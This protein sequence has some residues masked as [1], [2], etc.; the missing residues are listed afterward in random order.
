MNGVS[1]AEKAAILAH[2]TEIAALVERPSRHE[3]VKAK[4][5]ELQALLV[6]EDDC[7]AWDSSEARD[8]VDHAVI[9]WDCTFA[10]DRGYSVAVGEF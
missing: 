7:G 8:L 6:E 5:A 4:L 3:V 1:A 10:A 2:Y 9:A